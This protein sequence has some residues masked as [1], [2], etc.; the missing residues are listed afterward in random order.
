MTLSLISIGLADE[1][2]LT[3]RALEEAQS[4]DRLYAELYTMKL[5]TTLATLSDLSH[6]AVIPL[7]RGD[8]E[9]HSSH[10]IDEARTSRVG[11]FSGGD[12]LS[13]TTHISLLVEAAK[14]GVKAKVVHG[15]SIITAVAETGLSLYKFGRTIT[16][17]LPE[18][19]PVDSVV[20]VIDENTRQGL[21]TLIL[22]DLDTEQRRYMTVK[23]A[24]ESLFDAKAVTPDTLVVGAARIGHDTQVIKG[25]KALEVV[26]FPFGE[27][28]HV[29]IVPGNLHFAEEEALIHLAA[30]PPEVL[31]GRVVRTELDRLIEK[32][33]NGCK[34]VRADMKLAES[35]TTITEKQLRD[36]LDHA[37]R[38]LSDAEHYRA[39]RKP[40]S[41]TSVAYAEG[42]LDTLRLLGLVEFEW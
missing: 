38:Y 4:C 29:L 22:L 20:A 7:L 3:I 23:A 41:L 42:I 27:A 19:G 12:A 2:D 16:M 5:A 35:S 39:D 15:S 11:V 9:E 36:V 14:A 28:P 25:G 8:L 1:R 13:A 32:Y 18:K 31:K 17:P 26:D 40:T 6:K 37:D 33:I 21:H 34:R 24:L 10:I 30:C